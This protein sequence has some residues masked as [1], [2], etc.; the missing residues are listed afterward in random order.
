VSKSG[1]AIMCDP[2]STLRSIHVFRC[3]KESSCDKQRWGPV[4]PPVVGL[5]PGCPGYGTAITAIS[6]VVH[7]VGIEMLM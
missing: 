4:S 5:A 1:A 3:C 7:T 2:H 6:P